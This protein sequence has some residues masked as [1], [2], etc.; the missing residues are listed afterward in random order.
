MNI[1]TYFLAV[2]AFAMASFLLVNFGL[3]VFYGR[4]LIY[5][6]NPVVLTLEITLITAILTFCSY[7]LVREVMKAKS[8]KD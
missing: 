6:S 2:L 4:V 3:I 5:E 7:C 8:L 1:R